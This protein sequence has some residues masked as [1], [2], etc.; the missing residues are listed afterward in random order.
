MG[1]GAARAAPK[2]T[3]L[4]GVFGGAADGAE[5][6]VLDG[7]GKAPAVSDIERAKAEG[8]AAVGLRAN[9]IDRSSLEELGKAGLD[10]LVFEP[11]STP[12][13]ALLDDKVGYVMAIN[14]QPDENY[15]RSLSPLNLDAFYLDDLPS[16]LTVA[17]QLELTRIGV[18]GGRPIVARVKADADKTEL[19]CLRAAGVVVLLLEDASGLARLKETVM[20][21]PPRRARK[22]ERPSIAVALPR[23]QPEHDHDD[24]DDD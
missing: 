4:V 22:D 9:D 3:M 21:L 12:A 17:R 7:R 11:D 20:S 6:V 24:D 8:V 2:A 18:F 14:G 15:L 23:A 19:E 10:F 1:F 13:A 5:V 16:P